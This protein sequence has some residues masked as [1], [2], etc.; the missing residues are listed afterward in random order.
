MYDAA[1]F[2]KRADHCMRQANEPGLSR[3]HQTVLLRMASKWLELAVD[4]ERI[5]GLFDDVLPP[6]RDSPNPD[7][8]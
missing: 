4:A 1:E 8:N 6:D 2:R 7:L 3:R 5:G